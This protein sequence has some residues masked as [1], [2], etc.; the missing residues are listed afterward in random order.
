MRTKTHLW[1]DPSPLLSPSSLWP[2]LRQHTIE[3]V[4]D[5]HL[6]D[7][8]P[9]SNT[10]FLCYCLN[11]YFGLFS[12]FV[13]F[14]VLSTEV[15]NPELVEYLISMINPSSCDILPVQ[16]SA[17]RFSLQ[18]PPRTF[19]TLLTLCRCKST[20]RRRPM[21]LDLRSRL[22]PRSL[23]LNFR[24]SKIYHKFRYSDLLKYILYS[25]LSL[26]F[27]RFLVRSLNL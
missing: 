19:R 10:K 22:E 2:L 18:D 7:S 4:F 17:L 5:Q 14:Y 27:I 24:Q 8:S 6:G 3:Q 16:S 9:V 11:D 23:Y 1:P 15:L 25:Y 26:H 13:F 12:T 21:Y 20:P